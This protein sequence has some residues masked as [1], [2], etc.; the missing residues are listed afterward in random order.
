[1]NITFRLCTDG[2]KNFMLTAWGLMGNPF[3]H[4]G[5]TYNPEQKPPSRRHLA[6]QA[7]A[8][9]CSHK[10]L[11]S[12]I[13]AAGMSAEVADVLRAH[14]VEG[15]TYDVTVDGDTMQI[16]IEEVDNDKPAQQ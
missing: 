13:L 12:V 14:T 7:L 2:S 1:M 6:F 16:L 10:D 4:P 3:P 11:K 15:K 8:K 9:G 5:H